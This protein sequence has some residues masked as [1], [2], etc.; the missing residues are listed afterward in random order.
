MTNEERI[1]QELEKLD[2][3]VSGL[4]VAQATLQGEVN[5]NHAEVLGE[6]KNLSQRFNDYIDASK[7]R[8]LFRH[9]LWIYVGIAFS[10]LISLSN[11]FYKHGPK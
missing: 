7:E 3:D 2:A 11:W 6:V 5:T 4:K 10:V 1:L 8:R 9:N